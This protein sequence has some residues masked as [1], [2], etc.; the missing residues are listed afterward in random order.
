MIRVRVPGGWFEC[1][2]L[3]HCR[4]VFDDGS[5]VPASPDGTQGQADT[6]RDL[7]Y[8]AVE[9]MVLEHDLAHHVL[10]EC[11]GLDRSATLHAVAHGTSAPDASEEEALVLAFQRYARTGDIRLPLRPYADALPSWIER[12]TRYL[13]EVSPM[14]ANKHTADIDNLF[15]PKLDAIAEELG[16]RPRDMLAVMFSE[17]GVRADAWNKSGDASGLIQFMPATLRGLGWTHGPA[18]FRTKTA[19]EQLPFVRRYYSPHKDHLGSVAGLY[20]ATFLPA[21]LKHAGNPDFVLTAKNGPLGWA[22]APN[23][24]FDRNKDYAITVRELE[25]AVQRNARGPRWSELLARLEGGDLQEELAEEGFDLR[26]TIGI[27]RALD[28]LG[29]SPGPLDGIPGRKTQGA[30]I[31]YQTANGLKPDGIVGPLTRA[32]IETDLRTRA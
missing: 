26:T 12:W 17:S 21:L 19:T 24:V 18:A 7:G 1:W 3:D 22:Y 6:A 5:T 31:A 14:S 11:R 4:I 16:A 27:Q 29:F 20:V 28:R 15:F 9:R 10:A 2:G 30:V 23:A 25:D 13:E 8:Y 32:S